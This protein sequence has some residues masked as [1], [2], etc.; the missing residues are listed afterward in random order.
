MSAF[1]AQ[2]GALVVCG[3]AGDAL[4]DSIYEARLYVRGSVASLGA[5]CV[6]KELRDEHVAELRGLLERA[7]VDGATRPSSAATAPRGGCTTSTSTTRGVLMSATAGTRGCASPRRSTAT[8][9]PRSSAPRARGS[10]TSA[11]G[12]PSAACRTSTTCSSSARASRATRSRATASAATPTSCSATATPRKPLQLDI[13]ITIA[14]MSFGALSAPA[15]EALGRGATAMGTSTTTGDGGMT[16]EERGHSETLVYQLLPS[17]YGM[18]PD[19]LRRCDAIEIVIGQGA[20]PGG[21]GMLLGQKISDRVAEMRDLPQGIDQRSRL[22]ASRLDRAGRPRDQ[23]RRAARDHRLGEADLRQ[24][25]RVAH[26]LRRR[27]GGQ[28]G[29]RRDRARRDA[30]RHRRHAG[31]VHRARRH[32]DP[33]RDP[34]GRGGAAGARHAPQGA[35]RRVGRDPHRRGRR[36]GARARRR[37]GLDRR[38]RADRARRQRARARA[39]TPRSA[40]RPATTTTG[41]PAATRPGSRPRTTSSPRA[42]TPSSAAAGSRTTCA[43][44]CSRRRR[45]RAPA[46]SRT[47]TTSSPRTSSRSRSRPRRWPACRSRGRAGSPA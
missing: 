16:E 34:A 7:G 32:P 8:R 38:R 1:M 37:R 13:P 15:K 19:D 25:R 27:A 22:P 40:P 24:D 41:R 30:G 43:R 36:E 28:G 47:S 21:G 39:S 4:G 6:E 5:D 20:K 31:G 14:G 18:N 33:R 26:L 3:D 44:S 29:R 46:A 17:R 9:S 10:T 2:K 42:S 45:S 12:A 11:A 23:D 35:A